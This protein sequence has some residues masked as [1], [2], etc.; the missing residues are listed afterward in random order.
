MT[1]LASEKKEL[2][3]RARERRAEL[4]RALPDF[5]RR[6]VR[7]ADDL[8]VPEGGA[9]AGY[10][11]LGEEADP[12]R[13]LHA[14]QAHGH[15]ICYPRVHS[16]AHPLIFHVPVA[17]EPW[18]TGAFGIPEPRPDWPRAEPPI[19]LGPLLAFGARGYR[20]GCGRGRR[21]RS[22]APRSR[23]RGASG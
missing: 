13:L 17:H 12:A 3:E 7:Y 6:S 15:E 16:K 1:T 11:A 8:S 14:L 5:A 9:V 22:A 19:L 21:S 4:A 18:L 23:P 2:R 10:R 20:L